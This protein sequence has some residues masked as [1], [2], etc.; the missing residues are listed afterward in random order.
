M[1]E[2]EVL[3]SALYEL[4]SSVHPLHWLGPSDTSH[5]GTALNTSENMRHRARKRRAMQSTSSRP[6]MGSCGSAALPLPLLLPFLLPVPD[7]LGG[8][9]SAMPLGCTCAASA[10]VNWKTS[11]PAASNRFRTCPLEQKV[12]QMQGSA[13]GCKL[14]IAREHTSHRSTDTLT[15]CMCLSHS[16]LAT[17]PEHNPI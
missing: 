11:P 16:T 9:C 6:V 7:A 8:N 1:V 3:T 12:H 10:A 15:V 17:E 4:Q 5:T 14:W 2:R 13:G